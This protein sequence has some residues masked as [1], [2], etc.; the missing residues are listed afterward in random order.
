MPVL[1][2]FPN[3][4]TTHIREGVHVHRLIRW[5]VAVS[6]SIGCAGCASDPDRAARP[7]SSDVSGPTGGPPAR[8]VTDTT[9]HPIPGS[10][11]PT[12][13]EFPR[14]L[15]PFASRCIDLGFGDYHYFDESPVGP[16][17]GTVLMVHGNPTSSFLYRDVAVD[18]LKRGYRVIAMDHY[19]FGLSAK[20]SIDVFGYRPSDHSDVLTA[21]VDALDLRDMTV[22]VQDWGGPVGFGMAVEMPDRIKSFLIMNTWAWQV[23]GDDGNGV[24]G[25]LVRWSL[26][27]HVP[28]GRDAAIA[29]LTV[30]GAVVSLAA[31][32]PDPPRESI[33]SAYMDPFFDPWSGEVR[34]G[35][36][37]PTFRFALNILDD[38]R[39]FDRLG[40]LRTIADKP[41][42]F[43]F[44]G[45]DPLFGA[46]T[47]NPDGSCARGS[48]VSGKAGCVDPV[49]QY[50]YPYIER[51]T[52]LW[53]HGAVRGVE[54]NDSAGHFVQ[55]QAPA[56]VAQIVAEF[57]G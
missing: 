34:P 22:L 46:L 11:R 13:Y 21:F 3:V 9:A 15:Y 16:P 7:T 18:L 47:P 24:F 17:K 19:G 20:P 50:I 1:L 32:Y 33:L 29:G 36:T 41:V 53:E 4:S 6:M 54:I 8:E 45:A 56:R 44:G 43:Y 30:K 28:A 37:E 35:S 12:G 27:N 55:D 42:Y 5:S 40:S 25:S 2:K 52:Q 49:G 51:F 14:D 23:T 10:C 38:T 48:A 57:L 31:R 39:M 26:G